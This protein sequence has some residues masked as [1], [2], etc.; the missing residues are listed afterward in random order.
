MPEDGTTLGLPELEK[1]HVFMHRHG[2]SDPEQLCLTDTDRR[3][4]ENIDK[5]I[6]FRELI[7]IFFKRLE[8][9]AVYSLQLPTNLRI[10]IQR[11]KNDMF[12]LSEVVY[13]KP[14]SWKERT[15]LRLRCHDAQF[16]KTL[17][18]CLCP[19]L[20]T[21]AEKRGWR[22]DDLTLPLPTEWDNEL[23]A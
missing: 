6:G 8:L 20:W 1:F 9:K 5:S 10:G 18:S 15:H 14:G 3:A 22:P 2:F 7:D 11:E 13:G 19:D 17:W 23:K 12:R 21:E 4:L 16:W